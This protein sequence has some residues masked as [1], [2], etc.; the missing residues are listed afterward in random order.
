MVQNAWGA[1]TDAPPL[2]VRVAQL[3]YCEHRPWQALSDAEIAALRGDAKDAQGDCVDPPNGR[4]RGVTSIVALAPGA[5]PAPLSCVVGLMIDQ[6]S[7]VVPLD[8]VTTGIALQYD[9]PASQAPQ[10]VLLAVPA[11]KGT[12]WTP[13]QLR[14]IVRDTADLVRMRLVDPDALGEPH[15]SAD[16]THTSAQGQQT[17]AFTGALLP[18]LFVPMDPKQPDPKPEKM[19]PTLQQWQ[20]HLKKT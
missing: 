15:E 10:A 9:A 3:P 17:E 5:D 19:L 7:E 18:A 12:G 14:D 2:R 4:P 6:W 13:H 16:G 1:A 20:E 8:Q 11:R